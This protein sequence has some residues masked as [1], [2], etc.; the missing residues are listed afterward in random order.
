MR[1]E[2]EDEKKKNF[3]K[4]TIIEKNYKKMNVSDFLILE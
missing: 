3:I 1:D 2:E 4:L